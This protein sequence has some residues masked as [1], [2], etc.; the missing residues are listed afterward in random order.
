MRVL[1]I[2]A[3]D[4]SQERDHLRFAHVTHSDCLRIAGDNN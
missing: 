1:D 4:L 2:A 3:L